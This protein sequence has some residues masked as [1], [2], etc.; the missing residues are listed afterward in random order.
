M[1]TRCS[2]NL[3]PLNR[4]CH[5]FFV[6]IQ[7]KELT[8][9][10]ESGQPC[11]RCLW[12]SRHAPRLPQQT[13]KPAAGTIEVSIGSG[14]KIGIR[15][16]AQ[17]RTELDEDGKIGPVGRQRP[18]RALGRQLPGA[19][20]DRPAGFQALA[21]Q[22]GVQ[23]GQFTATVPG[24]PEDTYVYYA[25]SPEPVSAGGSEGQ[26][27]D[28]RRVRTARSAATA[29]WSRLRSKHSPQQGDNSMVNLEFDHKV[30][31]LKIS[32]PSNDLGEEISKI[33]LTFPNPRGHPT[34][35]TPPI[36]PPHRRTDGKQHP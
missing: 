6:D 17:T 25:V 27:P 35:W 19:D 12:C 22:R 34:R 23:Y 2:L 26:L 7:V 3:F 4:A 1:K 16:G 18:D 29:S 21:L 20:D 8:L 9:C 15:T 31:V 11:L 10:D 32:I 13:R 36:P 28:S 30:H 24:M 33:T 5:L 14:P